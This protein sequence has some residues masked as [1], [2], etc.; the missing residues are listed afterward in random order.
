MGLRGRSPTRKQKHHVGGAGGGGTFSSRQRLALLGINAIAMVFFV[1]VICGGKSFWS[2][3]TMNEPQ[4][5]VRH[6]FHTATDDV[7]RPADNIIGGGKGFHASISEDPHGING[8]SSLRAHRNSGFKTETKV[9]MPR[10]QV[11]N[12]IVP[13]AQGVEASEEL[14]TEESDAVEDFP[15]ANVI[16]PDPVHRN[17]MFPPQISVNGKTVAC[18]GYFAKFCKYSLDRGFKKVSSPFYK[19]KAVDMILLKY[20]SKG[21]Y[22][23]FT[24][25]MVN[26]VGGAT[27]CIGGGKGK[28]LRCREA[29]ATRDGCNYR[30][31]TVQPPQWNLAYPDQCR[32]FFDYANLNSNKDHIWIRKPGGAFHGRGITIHKGPE[33]LYQKYGS[34]QNKLSD[35]VIVQSYIA[36]PA[37]IGGH[38]FDFRTYLL[39]ASTKPFLPISS[40]HWATP[41]HTMA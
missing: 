26:C 35:G 22:K 21:K 29:L 31:L 16:P 17:V 27:S 9:S 13:D 32:H 40:P 33:E 7:W 19:G 28:Q 37:T 8:D 11:D 18:F 4:T 36:N 34:C 41:R 2:N 39:V 10:Q 20:S 24:N 14:Q 15:V 1:N 30:D 38:K 5:I 23:S 25:T 12:G 3:N 6:V